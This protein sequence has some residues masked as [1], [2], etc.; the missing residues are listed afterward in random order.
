MAAKGRQISQTAARQEEALFRKEKERNW[1]TKKYEDYY[2]MSERRRNSAT[3]KLLP[4]MIFSTLFLPLPHS[5]GLIGTP[6]PTKL[7]R[8]MVH[9][10]YC[11]RS[12]PTRTSA[13]I[14]LYVIPLPSHSGLSVPASVPR[15]SSLTR[16]RICKQ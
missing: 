15:I 10:V 4:V 7:H 6:S 14:V 3:G 16:V 13:E 5:M 11:K 9:N 1:N 12:L 8:H 2:S